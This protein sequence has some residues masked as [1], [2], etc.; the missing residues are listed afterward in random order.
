MIIAHKPPPI[1]KPRRGDTFQDRF[2]SLQGQI[3]HEGRRFDPR[4]LFSS[5]LESGSPMVAGI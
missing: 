3:P 1:S 2:T 4:T 5:L